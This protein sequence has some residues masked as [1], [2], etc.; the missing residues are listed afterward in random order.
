M[1]EMGIYLVITWTWN[2]GECYS[3]LPLLSL[4]PRRLQ[5]VEDIDE[6]SISHLCYIISHSCQQKPPFH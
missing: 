5:L 1:G 6:I 4:P 2:K 3:L